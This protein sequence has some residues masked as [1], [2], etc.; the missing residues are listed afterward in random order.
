MMRQHG[1]FGILAL[2]AQTAAALQAHLFV[3]DE[4]DRAHAVPLDFEEP[5]VAVG[6]TVA[7]VCGHRLDGIWHWSGARSMDLGWVSFRLLLFGRGLLRSRDLCGALRRTALPGAIRRTGR[8]GLALPCRHV[9]RDLFLRAAGEHA[10]GVR[11]D[12]P[13]RRGE[14]VAL[15][16][17]QPVLVFVLALAAPLHLHEREVALQLFA[18]QAE[19]EIAAR[20]LLIAWDAAEQLKR[21]AIPEHHATRAVVV[22]R[23]VSFE[24]AVLD[25]VIFDM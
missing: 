3:L 5:V 9:A 24:A 16:D 4:G 23:D 21:A 15:L 25:R 6:R 18:V 13:S 20:D 2:A 19:F 22:R 14:V 1:E 11:F 8:F 7:D 17:D 10:V 12:F